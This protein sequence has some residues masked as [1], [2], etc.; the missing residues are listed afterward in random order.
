MF[1]S[2][3]LFAWPSWGGPFFAWHFLCFCV[4]VLSFYCPLPPQYNTVRGNPVVMRA[5]CL[6][7]P[8]GPFFGFACVFFSGGG[9]GT[10]IFRF[11]RHDHTACVRA[12]R[13]RV[14]VSFY[15]LIICVPSAAVASAAGVVV[16]LGWVR[17]TH[18]PVAFWGV[19]GG[20]V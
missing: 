13:W 19:V 8:R 7:V 1:R 10:A 4:F 17:D 16:R 18:V 14:C 5:L 20:S 2:R 11:C 3:M 12:C 15:A 9:G 6:F